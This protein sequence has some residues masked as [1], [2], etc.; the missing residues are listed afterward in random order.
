MCSRAAR[1]HLRPHWTNNAGRP[2]QDPAGQLRLVIVTTAATT[3]ETTDYCAATEMKW[4]EITRSW[5]ESFCVI[6]KSI[7]VHGLYWRL[8]NWL[9]WCDYSHYIS[10]VVWTTTLQRATTCRGANR[11]NPLMVFSYP[12]EQCCWM[13]VV[14][15]HSRLS[16]SGEC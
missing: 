1:C 11:I 3:A 4:N 2:D 9:R 14:T 5:T 10:P 8:Q 15:L 7:T 6:L 12:V 13:V 16:W